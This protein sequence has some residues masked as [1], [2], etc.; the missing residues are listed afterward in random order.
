MAYLAKRK[1]NSKTYYYVARSVKV[2][3]VS[4][5]EII[6]SLGT[7]EDIIAT[8]QKQQDSGPKAAGSD[9]L[10]VEKAKKFH[11]ADVAALY[12]LA[13]RLNLAEIIDRHV[14]KRTQ[15]LSIGTYMVLAAINRVV[16]PVS[17]NSF[18]DWFKR[19]VLVNVIPGA[20]E[21]NLSS[22]SFWNHMVE[23]DQ[24]AISDIEDEVT[25]LLVKKY[26]IATDSLLFDN[27]NFFTYIATKNKSDIPKRG[28]CKSKRTDLKIVGLSLMVTPEYNIPLFHETYPG[29]RSDSVQFIEVINK[30]KHR[31]S[32]ICSKSPDV[33]LVFDKGN[34]S[35]HIVE[36]IED[37]EISQ[38]HFVGSLRLNQCPE[39]LDIN[40]S[41]YSPLS[42]ERL[43]GTSVYRY[44]KSVYGKELT[45][46]ATDNENLRVSQLVGIEQN[47]E[48]CQT[49]F[50][51]LIER[52][53]KR[54]DGVITKGKKPTYD[55]VSNNVKTILSGDHMK[56]IFSYSITD[57]NGH[58]SLQY[59]KDDDAFEFVKDKHLGKT[60]LFT[61][62][63]EWTSEQ[64]VSAYRSQYHVEESF[65]Q[66]KNTKFLSFRPIR[67]FTDR[68][69]TVHGFYCILAY[70]LSSLLKLE[71]S[72]LGFDMTIN[73]ILKDLS[74]GTQSF[75]VMPEATSNG[76]RLIS[77]L[78]EVSDPAEAYIEAY[79]LK[80]YIMQ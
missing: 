14:P 15:G 56:K 77:M 32:L 52:L 4:R 68:T 49:N 58:V 5:Q 55:S 29:N 50:N 39:I 70:M 43:E 22:Q 61:D 19:T 26:D 78:T 23:L 57:N 42:G 40:R 66:M 21:L 10:V 79:G 9:V 35:E 17:K 45:V 3:K 36:M 47:I 67:H 2:N 38:F 24:N 6:M 27:T 74:E 12:D 31:H 25:E 53:K 18:F 75:K 69:I 1:T 41:L 59:T 72:R 8:Q 33:T 20:N 71:M 16:E 37:P 11:F 63:D 28:H 65:K 51:D 76:L 34:N 48:K 80:K 60:I 62:R 7:I 44:K 64:I 73:A 46:V 13:K 54:E 30:L